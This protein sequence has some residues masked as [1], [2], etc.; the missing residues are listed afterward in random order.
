MRK[1]VY[2]LACL[3]CMSFL[4]NSCG[5]MFGGSKYNGTIKVKD[6]PNA[7]IFVNGQKLGNGQATSLFSRNQPI[8]FYS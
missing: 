4:F 8:C 2:L 3:F 7:E 5:V 6:K 1:K